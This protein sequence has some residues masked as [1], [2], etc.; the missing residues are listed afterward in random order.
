MSTL[1]YWCQLTL[2]TNNDNSIITVLVCNEWNTFIIF[3]LV[4]NHGR[5][6]GHYDHGF[7]NYS[8]SS[9]Y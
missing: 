9:S 2:P 4:N 3:D 8:I 7:N 6:Q 1:T 5:Y